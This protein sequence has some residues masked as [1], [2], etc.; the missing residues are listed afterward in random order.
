MTW[1]G[2]IKVEWDFLQK[3]YPGKFVSWGSLIE[4]QKEIIRGR[5]KSLDGFQ[6]DFSSPVPSPRKIDPEYAYTKPGPLYVD[7]DTNVLLGWKV[8]PGTE[9]EVLIV[10]KPV[11]KVLPGMT[12]K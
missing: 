6:T 7:I 2:A 9:L 12:K 4:E 5:H 1:F 10:Q 8:V 3:K 11:E